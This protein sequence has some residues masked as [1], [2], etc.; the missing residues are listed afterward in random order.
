MKLK[1]KLKLSIEEIGL[2]FIKAYKLRPTRLEA[3]YEIVKYCRL[4]DKF[5]LGYKFG[6]DAKE[7]CF[8][9]P[10]DILFVDDAIHKFKFMDELA[11]VAYY[12]GNHKLAIELNERIIHLYERGEINIGY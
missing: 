5:D 1:D 4:N 2:D 8:N 9:Y 6:K 3:L 12:A 10:K 11:I 7:T